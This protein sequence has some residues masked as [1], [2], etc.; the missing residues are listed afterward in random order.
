[1]TWCGKKW[2]VFALEPFSRFILQF[3]TCLFQWLECINISDVYV[4]SHASHPLHKQNRDFSMDWILD[5]SPKKHKYFIGWETEKKA[6]R[7][8]KGTSVKIP[9]LSLQFTQLRPIHELSFLTNSEAM[10]RQM[11]PMALPSKAPICA[12]SLLAV[13]PGNGGG[14]LVGKVTRVGEKKTTFTRN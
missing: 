8:H 3:T 9:V 5:S 1:M 10:A 11:L 4:F 14:G 12:A 2:E 7:S 6:L 13:K